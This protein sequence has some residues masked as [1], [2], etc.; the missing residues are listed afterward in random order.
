MEE[1]NAKLEAKIDELVSLNKEVTDLK[2]KITSLEKENKIRK[3]SLDNIISFIN[4]IWK[5]LSAKNKSSDINDYKA[6]LLYYF[7]STLDS[8][9][10]IKLQTKSTGKKQKMKIC[11]T[12]MFEENDI[13][14]NQL[15]IGTVMPL[16]RKK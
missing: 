12:L 14:K 13:Y 6:K 15:V 8:S 10:N 7:N 3:E 2:A 5:I 4:S 9:G 11:L 1:S 16:I